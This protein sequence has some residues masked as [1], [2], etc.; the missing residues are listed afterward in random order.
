MVPSSVPLPLQGL[1]QVEEMLI[2]RAFPVV[3]V[4]TKPKRW[5][6]RLQG[7]VITLPKMFSSLQTYCLEYLLSY[8][9]FG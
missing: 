2:A 8:L 7:H 4:Y 9:L 1:T 6:E 3:Q 5:S